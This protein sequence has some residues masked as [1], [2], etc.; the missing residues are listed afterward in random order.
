MTRNRRIVLFAVLIAILALVVLRLMLP[1]I[2]E[3]TV[4]TRLQRMGDYSGRVHDVDIA[5]WR[6]A[7]TLHGLRID[8]VDGEVPVPLLDAPRTVI[9]LSWRHLLRGRIVAEALFDQPTVHFV[10]GR[11]DGD[12]QT[13][14]GVDWR[15][16]LEA[17]TPT[18]VDE[19][20]I[21]DGRVVFHNFVSEPPVDIDMT[22]VEATV[23]NLT[24]VRDEAGERVAELEVTGTARGGARIQSDARFDPIDRDGDFQFALRVLEIDLTEVNDLAQAYANLDFESGTGELILEIEADDGRLT[25]YAKPLFKDIQIFSWRNDLADDKSN[26]FRIAWEAVVEGV[27]TVFKNQPA[28]QFATRIEISGDLGDAELGTLS[29]VVG[30]LRNAFVQALQPYFEGTHLRPRDT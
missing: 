16:R 9:S 3:R 29:A 17:L 12:S 18:R 19:V 22:G 5:L 28:D 23:R 10:D 14:R 2:V 20:V 25:G 13:G 7:Y 21:R 26:P 1:A 15:A 24:N 30:V 27:T 8:K 11:Q 6:G 4:N